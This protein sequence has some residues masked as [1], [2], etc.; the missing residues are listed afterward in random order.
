M[1]GRYLIRIDDICH[2]M[3]WTNWCK[4]KLI[5]DKL[6]IKPLIAVVP[7]NRDSD[8]IVDFHNSKFWDII[9]EVEKNGWTIGVHGYQHRIITSKKGLV[10]I[11]ARSEFAGLNYEIQK[12]K[13][14]RSLEIFN[15]N[16]IIPKVFVA[17]FHSF[18][19]N[20][21][22][23]LKELNIAFISDGYY[24]TPKIKYN[25]TFIPQQLSRVKIMPYG[26]WTICYHINNWG[27][28]DITKFEKDM[29]II[30]NK[31]ISFDDI[32]K[33]YK[34][35]TKGYINNMFAYILYKKRKSI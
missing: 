22:R 35:Q 30:K 31:I 6:H 33:Y 5:L 1:I 13:I 29:A 10:P 32:F 17:P 2:T 7:D 28:K 20:T 4:V 18:D 14:I 21:L 12:M 27:Q 34:V 16:R 23:V 9:K 3:N 24:I 8:L 26:L 25:V 15:A 11:N 19:I